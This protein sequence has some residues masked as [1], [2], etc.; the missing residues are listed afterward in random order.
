MCLCLLSLLLFCSFLVCTFSELHI[1]ISGS[2]NSCLMMIIEAMH[3]D[4]NMQRRSVKENFRKCLDVCSQADPLEDIT[5]YICLLYTS[6]LNLLGHYIFKSFNK[7][8]IC[9]SNHDIF[10]D[11]NSFFKQSNSTHAEGMWTNVSDKRFI[12][13]Q[14]FKVSSASKKIDLS[15][16][17]SYTTVED[18]KCKGFVIIKYENLNVRTRN[19]V[20][21][22]SPIQK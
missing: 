12:L 20:A 19:L 15:I 4:P 22:L 11:D 2:E 1:Q 6:S 17:E 8:P 16:F 10:L 7:S 3:I 5:P 18:C 14:S 13:F 9:V 21:W